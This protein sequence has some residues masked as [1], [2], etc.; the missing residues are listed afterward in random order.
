MKKILIF[1]SFFL[2]FNA[3]FFNPILD[4]NNIEIE[5]NRLV[6]EDISITWS[7]NYDTYDYI[8]MEISHRN[9]DEKY[10]L[11]SSEGEVKLCCYPDYVRVTI[12]VFVTKI[13]DVT[14]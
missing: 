10:E 8:V 11:S 5:I 2:F 7:V 1:L 9:N 12:T 13:E 6:G 14:G 3:S 4:T